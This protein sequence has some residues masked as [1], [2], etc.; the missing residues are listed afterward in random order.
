MAEDVI[1][2]G[3]MFCYLE[4]VLWAKSGILEAVAARIKAGCKRFNNVTCVLCKKGLLVKLRRDLYIK[5]IYQKCNELQR[6]MPAN[7]DKHY[8]ENGVHPNKNASNDKWHDTE[9]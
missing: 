1:E 8:K 7:K 5:Y 4:N 3:K 6:R 9:G 2:K